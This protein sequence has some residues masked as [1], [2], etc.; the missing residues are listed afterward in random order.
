MAVY[1]IGALD[2]HDVEKFKKY[3]EGAA[4][5][6][7]ANGAEVLAVGTPLAHEGCAPA[8]TMALLKFPDQAAFDAWYNSAEYLEVKP[9]RF[10][11][12]T[13]RIFVTLQ[14]LP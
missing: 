14:G 5:T 8:S 3:S 11:S 7:R 13:S 9:L 12:G 2:V 6:S 1:M 4:R 10:E